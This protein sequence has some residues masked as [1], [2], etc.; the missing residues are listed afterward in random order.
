MCAG[1]ITFEHSLIFSGKQ[2]QKEF[3]IIPL[4]EY[5]HDVLSY[6]DIGNLN[7]EINVLVSLNRATNEELDSISKVI[8]YRK[9]RNYLRTKYPKYA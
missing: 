3:A 2:V 6:Q 9:L 7:K 4:C 8:N 1:R 5:H